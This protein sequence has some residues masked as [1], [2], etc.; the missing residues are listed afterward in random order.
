[1]AVGG[2]CRMS[3]TRDPRTYLSKFSPGP[4]SPEAPDTR[5]DRGRPRTMTAILG[6]ALLVLLGLILWGVR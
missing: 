6:G 3:G 1:M 4:L 5:S 2:R